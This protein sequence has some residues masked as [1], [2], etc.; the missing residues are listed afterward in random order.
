MMFDRKTLGTNPHQP[1]IV[2]LSNK[3]KADE[4]EN[5]PTKKKANTQKAIWLRAKEE[6][7]EFYTSIL[8]DYL[9]PLSYT[10]TI[11][12]RARSSASPSCIRRKRRPST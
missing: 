9:D 7:T 5:K 3:V 4:N 11:M 12:R 8:K 6:Y 1:V 2:D 10:H